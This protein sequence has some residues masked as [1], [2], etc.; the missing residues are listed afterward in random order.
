MYAMDAESFETAQEEFMKECSHEK[1]RERIKKFL[2]RKKEWAKIFR[3]DKMSRGHHTNNYVE[4]SIRILKEIILCRT[5]AYNVVALVAN[6]WEEYF[7]KRLLHYA[8]LR[9]NRPRQ[10]YNKLCKKLN[11]GELIKIASQ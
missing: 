9:E 7:V 3:T 8:Y 10:L 1:Y 11:P 5:K 4:A 2:R 6:V